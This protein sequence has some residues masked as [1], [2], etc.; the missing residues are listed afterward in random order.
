LFTVNVFP[1]TVKT[2]VNG[3]PVTIVPIGSLIDT[4]VVHNALV[5]ERKE[6]SFARVLSDAGGDA[7]VRGRA[8]GGGGDGAVTPAP[9]DH[10]A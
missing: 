10:R 3:A 8:G 9:R 5:S 1:S 7:Q 4:A 2:L 6:T